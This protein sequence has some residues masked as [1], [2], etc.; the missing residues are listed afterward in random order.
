[1]RGSRKGGVLGS[2]GSMGSRRR[3]ALVVKLR[4]GLMLLLYFCAIAIVAVVAVVVVVAVVIAAVVVVAAVGYA[5]IFFRLQERELGFVEKENHGRGIRI[6][7]RGYHPVVVEFDAARLVGMNDLLVVVGGYQREGLIRLAPVLVIAQGF[8]L[9]KPNGNN[10]V[11]KQDFLAVWHWDLVIPN[12]NE[13][14]RIPVCL[15]QMI[16]HFDLSRVL[17]FFFFF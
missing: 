9:H 17:F 10:L 13:M 4:Q 12:P 14:H 15:Q 3:R 2:M 5:A 11:D 6:C 1:M 7:T 16:H 8:F